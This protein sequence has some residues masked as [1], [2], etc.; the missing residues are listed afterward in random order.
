MD[1]TLRGVTVKQ[2]RQALRDAAEHVGVVEPESLR[3]P[4]W[5]WFRASEA[6][7]SRWTHLLGHPTVSVWNAAQAVL[8]EYARR[9]AGPS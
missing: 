1:H 3:Q 4:L 2:F 5:L 8:N 7:A 9:T 6:D